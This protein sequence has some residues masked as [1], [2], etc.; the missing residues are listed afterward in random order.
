MTIEGAITLGAL[1][2][3]VGEVA[4]L[5]EG[6]AWLSSGDAASAALVAY[7]GPARMTLLDMPQSMEIS[8]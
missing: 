2:L 8:A 6:T 1:E 4:H 7:P 3:G 5:S